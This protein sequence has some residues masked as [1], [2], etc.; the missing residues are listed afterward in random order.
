MTRESAFFEARLRVLSDEERDGGIG[1]LGEKTLH[2]IV[3]CTLEPDA[4]KHEIKVA[5]SVADIKNE[6]G[7]LEVQ[8]RS[9]YRL[10]PKLKRFLAESKVTVVYPIARVRTVRW[11]DRETGEITPPRKSPKKGSAKDALRELSGLCEL[12]GHPSLAVLLLYLD[13]EDYRSLDG[14]GRGGKRGSTRA[15]RI[16]LAYVRE[17]R[18]STD[19]DYI[20]LFL[21]PPFDDRPFT[22]KEY[23][24][25]MKL[26]EKDAYLGIR[27]LTARGVLSQVG[28]NG[29][30]YLYQKL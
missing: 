6:S 24:K 4:T 25:G 19:A 29:R 26:K 10:V 11:I 13:V 12:I 27:L 2:R 1:T 5:R 16:P 22:V 15:E 30:A 21:P 18:L 23:A 7:I 14:W 28:K 17:D 9:L 20:R 8:T 3:K